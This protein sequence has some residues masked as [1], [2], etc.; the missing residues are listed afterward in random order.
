MTHDLLALAEECKEINRRSHPRVLANRAASAL[1]GAHEELRTARE[2]YTN[3]G[4][5]RDNL[6]AECDRL[7]GELEAYRSCHETA[8]GLL[9][10]NFAM[11]N[12][13]SDLRELVKRHE[14]A[15]AA[16][17]ALLNEDRED[18]GI[19]MFQQELLAAIETAMKEAK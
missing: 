11:A 15:L 13:L 4:S 2:A 1:R 5:E 14:D 16:T 12:E 8:P 17:I 18:M 9:R 3:I 6:Q 10:D 7:R 19:E